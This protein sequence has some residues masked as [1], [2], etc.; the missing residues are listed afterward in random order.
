[1]DRI[2]W[3]SQKKLLTTRLADK[4]LRN[5]VLA[6]NALIHNHKMKM[7]SSATTQQQQQKKYGDHPLI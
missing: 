4:C 7:N 3:L 5:A 6:R 1:M 2:I